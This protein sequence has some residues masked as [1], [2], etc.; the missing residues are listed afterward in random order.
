[1]I[2]FSIRVQ[3]SIQSKMKTKKEENKGIWSGYL[4]VTKQMIAGAEDGKYQLD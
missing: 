4:H 2:V 1:M 3:L